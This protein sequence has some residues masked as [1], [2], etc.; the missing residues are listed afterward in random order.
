MTNVLRSLRLA[1]S[2]SVALACLPALAQ[3]G[4]APA[5]GAAPAAPA[6][7]APVDPEA[8]VAK[9][10]DKAIT[11]RDLAVAAQDLGP[12]FAQVPPEQRRIAVLSALID[13]DVLAAKAEAEKLTEDKDVAAE[14][15]FA[16]AQALHSA[17]FAKTGVPSVTDEEL[18]SRYDDEIAK[19][20][21]VDEVKASHI[22]VKTKEEAEAVIKKLDAGEDFN[23]LA[24]ENSSGPSGPEGGDLGYFGPGQM[25]PAF[26]TAA[27]ALEPGTYTKQPV[28]TQFGWH[29]I[30]V[31][32]KR[33]Q[34]PPAFDEVKEQ[35]RQVVLREKYVDL[36]QK[37]RADANIE[38]VDP[39]I[40]NQMKAIEEMNAARDK[41]AEG[42]APSAN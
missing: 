42:A 25:V 28:E 15:A 35:V 13:I 30:K 29:V 24:A 40:A 6:P 32:D 22:L 21:P 14:V 3:D 39:A 1:A 10:G 2:L 27:F 37:A 17:Y 41:P 7:A 36:V 4:G 38:Y 33:K 31:D 5:S 9:V 18:K 23:K 20:P 19:M 11:E 8:V 12:Q 26:E 34:A 16:R